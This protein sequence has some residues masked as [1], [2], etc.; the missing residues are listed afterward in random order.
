VPHGVRLL[1]Q[2]PETV[3]AVALNH[4]I[5]RVRDKEK[6]A[7]YLT[8]LLGLPAP[9]TFGHFLVVELSNGVSLDFMD[10]QEPVA[11]QHYAFLISEPEFDQI[12]GRIR[13]DGL[14]Y[15]A[16]PGRVREGQIN[17]RDG[18]RGLYFEDPDGHLLE[19]LT[20]PYGKR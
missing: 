16:D 8:R 10:T 4:T 20:Q 9:V 11:S 1:P 18:G 3:M 14:R 19:I 2:P 13:A 5:V 7:R 12:Y 15:W 6:S 17:R